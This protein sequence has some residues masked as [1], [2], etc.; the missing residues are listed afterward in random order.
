MPKVNEIWTYSGQKPTAKETIVEIMSTDGTYGI[1][2]FLANFSD[3]KIG[4][5]LVGKHRT[6]WHSN[7]IIITRL[8]RLL[9]PAQLTQWS[10]DN[11]IT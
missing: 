5:L 6:T 3:H 8:Q 11:E 7:Q 9:C 4:T 1:G 10:E 2:L